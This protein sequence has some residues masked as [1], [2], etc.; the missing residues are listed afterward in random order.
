M[1]IDGKNNYT[2]ARKIADQWLK[3]PV[4]QEPTVQSLDP[5]VKDSELAGTGSPLPQSARALV[6][7]RF[8]SVSCSS[9]SD[10]VT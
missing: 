6:S 9:S 1:E 5:K 10:C 8:G 2:E 7:E 4:L 3:I